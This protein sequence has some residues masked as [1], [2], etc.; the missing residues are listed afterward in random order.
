MR[1]VTEDRFADHY[2]DDNSTKDGKYGE[3]P[4]EPSMLA[5]SGSSSKV[6]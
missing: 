5:L 2:A 6:T 3:S 4:P 1:D